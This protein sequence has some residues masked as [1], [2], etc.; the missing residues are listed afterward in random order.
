MNELL[1]SLIKSRKCPRFDQHDKGQASNNGTPIQ[2]LDSD[3]I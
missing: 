2:T 1:G 3:I